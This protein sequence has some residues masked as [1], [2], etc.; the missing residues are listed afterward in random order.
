MYQLKS[1]HIPSYIGQK[2]YCKRFKS[3]GELGKKIFTGKFLPV[4]ILPSAKNSMTLTALYLGLISL[5]LTNI[6][7][8]KL[9]QYIGNMFQKNLNVNDTWFG[10][11]SHF[12][13][14]IFCFTIL[15]SSGVNG[16]EDAVQLGQTRGLFLLQGGQPLFLK[17]VGS[18]TCSAEGGNSSMGG[19]STG[20]CSACGSKAGAGSDVGVVGPVFT[21]SFGTICRSSLRLILG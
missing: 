16:L 4:A 17:G 1:Y 2:K 20:G 19:P 9:L 11:Y 8:S 18:G 21:T 7:L 3:F 6:F 5:A 12:K 14:V 15:V 13:K 10:F